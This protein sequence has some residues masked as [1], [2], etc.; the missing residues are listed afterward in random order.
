ML[1]Q[2]IKTSAVKYSCLQTKTG[3]FAR[4]NL[5]CTT[6][7]LD[8]VLKELNSRLDVKNVKVVK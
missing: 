2:V 7:N 6:S 4:R 1:N 5:V 8:R 3:K